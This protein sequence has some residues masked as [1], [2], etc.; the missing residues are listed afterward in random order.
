MGLNDARIIEGLLAAG[1]VGSFIANHATFAAEIAGC[2]AEIGAASAMAAA[3][4]VQLMNGS[5]SEGFRAAT[6]AMHSFMGL[7]CDPI[8][9]ITEIR[10]SSATPRR[11]PFP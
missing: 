11:P 8:G 4:V 1:L 6:I 7:I 9:G 10:A 3:G 2:Q 5:A